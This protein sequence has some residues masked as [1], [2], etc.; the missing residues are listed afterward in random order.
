[1]LLLPFSFICLLYDLNCCC[2]FSLSMK[3]FSGPIV[4]ICSNTMDTCMGQ[5]ESSL[6]VYLLNNFASP[7][8]IKYYPG[9]TVLTFQSKSFQFPLLLNTKS[10]F[11]PLFWSYL[12]TFRPQASPLYS[13]I[14]N[15][16]IQYFRSFFLTS[17]RGLGQPWHPL[18]RNYFPTSDTK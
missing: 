7:P 5:S 1:M 13:F 17:S 2:P 10:N 4:W 3:C 6:F 14:D 18:R 15:M 9:F 16:I 12:F 8:R 11:F